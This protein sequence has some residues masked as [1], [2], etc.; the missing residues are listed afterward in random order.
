M[1][2]EEEVKALAAELYRTT[3]ADLILARA[4]ARGAQ[5]VGLTREEALSLI[6]TG[7]VGAALQI[8]WMIEKVKP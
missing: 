3:P 8:L 1:M 2:T 5:L 6:P 7:N 4:Y